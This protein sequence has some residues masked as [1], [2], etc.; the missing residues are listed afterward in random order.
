MYPSQ[1]SILWKSWSTISVVKGLGVITATCPCCTVCSLV[2]ISFILSFHS[3]SR[4]RIMRSC[5]KLWANFWEFILL[6]TCGIFSHIS[7]MRANHM[8]FPTIFRRL[9][10]QFYRK[11]IEIWLMLLI[12]CILFSKVISGINL[13]INITCELSHWIFSLN[14]MNIW[15]YFLYIQNYGIFSQNKYSLQMLVNWSLF[16]HYF[17]LLF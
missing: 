12:T 6:L 7:T 5:G 14:W 17:L 4:K 11:V 10:I 13:T 8:A 15:K 3:G 16:Y 2:W 9:K 1:Q